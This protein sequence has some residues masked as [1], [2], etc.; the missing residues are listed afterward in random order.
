[1]V[2]YVATT[3]SEDPIIAKNVLFKIKE[4]SKFK[5]L[6][7]PETLEKAAFLEEIESG[8]ARGNEEIVKRCDKEEKEFM[9]EREM[10]RN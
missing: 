8:R 10:W 4:S 2:T 1:M 7:D 9:R 3:K 6:D 5:D